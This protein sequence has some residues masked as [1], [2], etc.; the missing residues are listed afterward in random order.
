MGAAVDFGNHLAELVDRV[1]HVGF[2]LLER[3]LVG[4]LDLL[5]QVAL[6]ERPHDANHIIDT[7][8]R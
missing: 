5:G 8:A 2:H 3:P 1:V 7:L 6:R 4:T